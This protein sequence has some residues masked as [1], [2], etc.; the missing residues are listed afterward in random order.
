MALKRCTTC[1]GVK[2]VIGLGGLMRKCFDCDGI[3]Y[4][5]EATVNDV[6]DFLADNK[7]SD[8]EVKPIARRG[9]P[10]RGD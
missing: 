10:K 2:S 1:R 8:D 6:D 9:R 5:E 4:K 3:G 7:K